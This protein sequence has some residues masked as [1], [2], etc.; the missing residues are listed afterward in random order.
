[1]SILHRYD[2]LHK[3]NDTALTYKI[4]LLVTFDPL[5]AQIRDRPSRPIK[6]IKYKFLSFICLLKKKKIDKKVY[7]NVV[8]SLRVYISFRVTIKHTW[9]TLMV[10]IHSLQ[11]L[12]VFQVDGRCR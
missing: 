2:N 4:Q 10:V 9:R 7:Q 8:Q 6:S 1:M 11:C 5:Q 3:S 12:T